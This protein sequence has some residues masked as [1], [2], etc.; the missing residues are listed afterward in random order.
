MNTLSPH[1]CRKKSMTEA[2]IVVPWLR[3]LKQPFI[4]Q[5]FVIAFPSTQPL[6]VEC[7]ARGHRFVRRVALIQSLMP[8]SSF[9]D[10]RIGLVQ[11]E[12]CAAS[13]IA[14]KRS[15]NA[16]RSERVQDFL[17]PLD[18]EAVQ[19]AGGRSTNEGEVRSNDAG[20]RHLR[21]LSA[22]VDRQMAGTPPV[23]K[24]VDANT[25]LVTQSSL[26]LVLHFAGSVADRHFDRFNRATQAVKACNE[27]AEPFVWTK[28]KVQQCA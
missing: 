2:G 25:R 12:D 23:C 18:F 27:D 13:A 28:F 17:H 24:I 20:R 19:S 1:R 21:Q 14:S 22:P 4:I 5:R 26:G 11:S 3:A 16:M 15:K 9:T 6:Q 8:S 7:D 10:E